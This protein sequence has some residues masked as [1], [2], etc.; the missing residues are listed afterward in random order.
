M[1]SNGAAVASNRQALVDEWMPVTEMQGDLQ[2][3]IA[4]FKKHCAL[5][6]KHGEM[7]VAI[8]PNLTGMAVHPK[9]EILMNVLDPSRSVENNFRTYQI[10]TSDGAVLTGMLAGESANAL[11]LINTQGK[12]EQVLREDIEQMQTGSKSLMPEG[13]ES[14]ISR[15]R[16]G[17]S[18]DVPQ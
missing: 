4:M 7:G 12:E 5:C 9:A 14:Q 13:F 8:G 15:A 3:G 11:R 18:A 2:N 6:H 10:L 1:E 16:D 17:G